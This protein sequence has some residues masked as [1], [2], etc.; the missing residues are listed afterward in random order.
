MITMFGV[1]VLVAS[2][3]VM[4]A[5]ASPSIPGGAPHWSGG[6]AAQAA[7]DDG[8]DPCDQGRGEVDR[9]HQSRHHPLGSQDE[10]A[11]LRD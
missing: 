7:P 3:V 9:R 5:A 6:S 2:L 4:P 11:D 10:G 8:R 1:S